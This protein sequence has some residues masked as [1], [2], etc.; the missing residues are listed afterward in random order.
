[1]PAST[2]FPMPVCP[3]ADENPF[4]QRRYM[5]TPIPVYDVALLP[6]LI[7][8]AHP[9]WVGMYNHAWQIGFGNLRQ[10][11]PASGFVSN[12]I[13]TAFNKNTFMWDSCFMTM[14]GRYGRRVFDFMG[15]L[16][17][18]YA[19]QHHTG[20]ICREISTYDGADFFSPFDPRGTGPNIMAWTEWVDFQQTGD[21]QRLR[22]V[23]PALID[24]H[25]WRKAWRTWP[26]GGYWTTGLV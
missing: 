12:F 2:E 8:D 16:D 7:T 9:E 10:P 14:F 20:F 19:K 24:Y 3:P 5:P 23:F 13:D 21:V 1:M 26:D 4:L 17:N 6:A 11:E 15:T 22:D 25:R 18:F